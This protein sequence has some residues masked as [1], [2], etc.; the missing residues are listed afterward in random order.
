MVF[1]NLRATE[2]SQLHWKRGA[3]V[4]L[5]ILDTGTVF[6]ARRRYVMLLYK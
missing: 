3:V 1:N 4:I 6:C 2:T 5:G